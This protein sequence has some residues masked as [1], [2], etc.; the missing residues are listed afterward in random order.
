MDY[1]Y[2]G[3]YPHCGCGKAPTLFWDLHP[4]CVYHSSNEHYYTAKRNF[5]EDGPPS[6]THC[7]AMRRPERRQWLLD[8]ERCKPD[9][10][11]AYVEQ[12][13]PSYYRHQSDVGQAEGEAAWARPPSQ[14]PDQDEWSNFRPPVLMQPPPPV[15][16]E[17][18]FLPPSGVVTRRG[19]DTESRH[20]RS[21][22]SSIAPS[23][24]ADLEA[25]MSSG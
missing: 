10:A 13:R 25:A 18:Y 3:R 16:N 24:N 12:S 22:A 15:D 5:D 2:S 11:K 1:N 20:S 21:R 9:A 14:A 4:V 17:H 19:R 7:R 23:P 6:C 8:F